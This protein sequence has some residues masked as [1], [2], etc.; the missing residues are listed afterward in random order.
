MRGNLVRWWTGLIANLPTNTLLVSQTP[1]TRGGRARTATSIF[2][3]TVRAPRWM[4]FVSTGMSLRRAVTS[5]SK[6]QEDDGEPFEEKMERLVAE[7]REQQTES[8]RLDARITESLE[9]LDFDRQ[10]R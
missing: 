4:K 3:A 10:G 7:L 6:P 5:A 1:I 2:P 9:V 8:A